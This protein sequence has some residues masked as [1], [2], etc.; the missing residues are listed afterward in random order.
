MKSIALVCGEFHRKSVEMMVKYAKEEAD[1]LG[2][3][4]SDVV[5]VPGSYE[6]PL[7]SSRLL[8]QENILGVACLGVIERG[9]T[10]HGLVIGQAVLSS[11]L[12]LQI[13]HNK[14]IGLGIIGPGAENHHIAPR[15]EPHARSAI[16]A[17]YSMID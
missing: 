12:N 8:S 10:D 17:V 3:Q 2:I 5:W 13:E 7:A 16:S 9:E 4:I 6:V 15:L 11:L 14:P 1:S